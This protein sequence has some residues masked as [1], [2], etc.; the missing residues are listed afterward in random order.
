MYL[1]RDKVH[2]LFTNI[3]YNL[4]INIYI[5]LQYLQSSIKKCQ[6]HTSELKI[7]KKCENN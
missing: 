4:I 6:E 3:I 1:F 5:Y 7:K 2:I